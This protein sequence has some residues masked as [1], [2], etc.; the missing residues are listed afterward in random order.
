MVYDEDR[1]ITWLADANLAASNTFGLPTFFGMGA[2]PDDTSGVSG[3][4]GPDGSMNWPGALFWIDAMSAA[5][6]LGFND[7]RLPTTVVPD[8]SY[9]NPFDVPRTDSSG[10]NCTG[11][12]MGH[13]FYDEFGAEKFSNVST[14]GDPVEL[15]KF[16]NVPDGINWSGT[17]LDSESGP[18]QAWGFNFGRADQQSLLVDRPYFAWA[19]RDGDVAAVPNGDIN[20]DGV[21]N[22]AD[23]LLGQQVLLIDAEPLP[24][25]QLI[26][27]D[28][29][30]LI[31]GQPE[32]D[33]EFTLGDLLVIERKVLGVFNF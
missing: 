20:L 21:V 19:V 12:E 4:I 8:Y 32:P 28:V 30:P 5:N 2:H 27:G 13:M 14:S 1:N 29:A 25:E 31:D 16:I 10:W 6:Y 3:S 33:G 15:A 7:W 11:S 18:S 26:H 23:V 17:R 9:T 24:P 22:V